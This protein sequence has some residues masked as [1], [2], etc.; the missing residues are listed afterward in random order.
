MADAPGLLQVPHQGIIT[1]G[2][3][4][5]CRTVVCTVKP[6]PIWCTPLLQYSS[7]APGHHD[8]QSLFSVDRLSASK[9]WRSLQHAAH[10]MMRSSSSLPRGGRVGRRYLPSRPAAYSLTMG[11]VFQKSIDL[12]RTNKTAAKLQDAE[13]A[14]RTRAHPEKTS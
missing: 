11:P 14:S 5:A 13:A 7:T 10:S 12:V 1:S 9:K 8:R 3:D 6:L 4:P 2:E